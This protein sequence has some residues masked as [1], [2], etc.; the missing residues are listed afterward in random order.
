MSSILIVDDEPAICWAFSEA[1][2]DDG[3]FVRVVPSAEEALRLTEGGW[4]PDVVVMDVRL[5]GIDGL[6]AIRELRE[7]IGMTPV[8]VITAF[9]SLETAVRAIEEGAFEYLI[10]PFDL[11]QA[12]E[13]LRRALDSTVRAG[14]VGDIGELPKP[15]AGTIVGSSPGMQQVFKQIALVAGSDVSVLIT[16]ES[17]TGKELVARAIHR[18]SLR[19]QGPFLPVCIPAL[20]PGLIESELFGHLR[21]S[22]TGADEDRRGLFEMAAGGTVLLDEIADVPSSVQ[23]KLLRA[24]EQREI[25]PVGG[26]IPRSLDV[27]IL[28]A[29]NRPLPE[30][31]AGGTFRDD[32]FFRLGVFQIHLPP[33]RDRPEDVLVLTA[34][35]LRQVH[36]ALDGAPW[37]LS[38][39]ARDELCSRSWAGNVRELRNVIEHAAIVARGGEIRPEHFPPPAPLAGTASVRPAERA[40]R[41]I[42]GWTAD[43][44]Q[45]PASN[46]DPQLYERFLQM[47]EP[48]LLEAVLRHCDGNRAAAAQLLGLHRGTLRQKMRRHGLGDER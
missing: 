13:V 34:H 38:E 29:T 15:T 47:V 32:L 33:L 28:A 42:S 40:Q 48:P 36:P 12:V 43:A 2:S 5:P 46:A 3:H 1:L 7:R 20:N 19:R 39:G 37:Q 22:F 21:G 30:L 35:F 14:T 45:E 11:D 26:A 18:H 25:L 4:R 41:E 23:V 10:K 9:G 24:I 16:G 17:G 31:I 6:S 27:R 44:V 8:V